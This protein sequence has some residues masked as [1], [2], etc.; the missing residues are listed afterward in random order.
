MCADTGVTT[1]GEIS[2]SGIWKS[3]LYRRGWNGSAAA[4]KGNLASYLIFTIYSWKRMDVFRTCG[5]QRESSKTM[6][7][8]KPQ[9]SRT[10]SPAG[11]KGSPLIPGW[12]VLSEDACFCCR[13]FPVCL[14]SL[15]SHPAVF[16]QTVFLWAVKWWVS[17]LFDG[18]HK[19]AIGFLLE[20][21]E[22]AAGM[23]Y[24]RD[25]NGRQ[26]Y[27]SW[28]YYYLRLSIS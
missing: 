28:W 5:F 16:L 7:F 21:I 9:A 20:K 14:Q 1:S 19:K 25:P 12:S 22:A 18:K 13:A 23:R 17:F 6:S 15:S 26:L 27:S 4:N 10:E 11:K 24:M 2:K 8:T 3:L